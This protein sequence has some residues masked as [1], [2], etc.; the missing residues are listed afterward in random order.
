MH[1][2]Q[3]IYE[4]LQNT[5]DDFGTAMQ[6]L[7]GK[8]AQGYEPDPRSEFD[9][10][11]KHDDGVLTYVIDLDFVREH[12]VGVDPVAITVTGVPSELQRRKDE[13]D[14]AYRQRIS[15]SFQDQRNFDAARERWLMQ[16]EAFLFQISDHFRTKIGVERIHTEARTFMP[17]SRD[18]HGLDTLTSFGYPLYGY[19]PT[20]DLAYLLMWDSLWEQY[21]F[22]VR[23]AYYG[24]YRPSA[25]NYGDS[26]SYVYVGD[27]GWS[28]GDVRHYETTHQVPAEAGGGGDVGHG[29]WNHSDSGGGG[30]LSSIGDCFSSDS[31]GGDAGGGS[32]SS[33][34]SCGSGGCG[35]GGE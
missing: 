20:Y 10:V 18:A 5:P 27:V 25:M 22:R 13:D 3:L 34:S 32:G 33:C 12:E 2:P 4:D 31:G 17:D 30:W 9:L 28:Y 8:L 14:D 29:A 21:R 24:D 35:G 7:Q 19:D 6:A 23:D 16:L 26:T 15:I 1:T 11:L